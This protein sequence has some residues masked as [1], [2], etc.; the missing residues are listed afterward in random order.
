MVISSVN[1][2]DMKKFSFVNEW[3]RI[4]FVLEPEQMKR[5]E[6]QARC[7]CDVNYPGA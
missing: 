6:V 2:M 5:G 3:K 7:S 4:L 1:S